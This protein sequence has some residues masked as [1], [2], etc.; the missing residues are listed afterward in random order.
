MLENWLDINSLGVYFYLV[1]SPVFYFNLITNSKVGLT[2]GVIIYTIIR[3]H[4]TKYGCQ[5][6]YYKYIVIYI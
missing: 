2:N 3:N 5:L 6:S 1:C 4:G